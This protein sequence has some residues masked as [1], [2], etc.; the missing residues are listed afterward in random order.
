VILA[1]AYPQ[2]RHFL[3]RA[4][5]EKPQAVIVG[6]AESA[7]KALALARQL[8]PDV[9]IIDSY[10]P[11][12]FSIDNVPLSRIGGLDAAES[13]SQEM[14][15]TRVVLVNNTEA[16]TDAENVALTLELDAWL[17][18]ERTS[19]SA[20]DTVRPVSKPH[21]VNIA[22]IGVKPAA[23]AEN[24]DFSETA[25][26]LGSLALLA[27]LALTVTMVLAII[28]APIAL[29]GIV[30]II[31]GVIGKLF[32]SNPDTGRRNNSHKSRRRK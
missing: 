11:H 32:K 20:L 8:R 12:N 18:R 29:A 22:S 23:P 14:P 31:G 17:T 9:A 21:L 1:T 24:S 26:F 15:D 6:E 4:I 28:G 3:T 27:G 13:I 16:V 5:A 7:G 30:A 19:L 10:L 2:V 25:I